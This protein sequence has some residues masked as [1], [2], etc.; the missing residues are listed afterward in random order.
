[1][2]ETTPGMCEMRMNACVLPSFTLGSMRTTLGCQTVH[3]TAACL[4]GGDRCITSS[5]HFVVVAV[6]CWVVSS[7]ALR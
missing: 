1:M 7:G 4:G 2:V 5:E 6:T 3:A